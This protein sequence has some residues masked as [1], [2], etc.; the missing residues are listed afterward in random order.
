[1]VENGQENIT[2]STGMHAASPKMRS[3]RAGL[4]PIVAIILTVE[5]VDTCVQWALVS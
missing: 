1:L 4:I 5:I 3:K 2:M